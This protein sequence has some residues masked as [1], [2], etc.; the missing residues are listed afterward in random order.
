MINFE[1]S[2]RDPLDAFAPLAGDPYSALIYGGAGDSGEPDGATIVAFPSARLEARRGRA[3][4]D[5]VEV[6]DSFFAALAGLHRSRRGLSPARAQARG[7]R[8]GLVGFLG[9]ELG[10]EIEPSARGPQSPYGLPDAA[11]GAYDA[12]AIFDLAGCRTRIVARDQRAADRLAVA[13]GNGGSRGDLRASGPCRFSGLRSNFA[14][15]EYEAAVADAIEQIRRGAFFQVNLSQR[16]TASSSGPCLPIDVFCRLA[17]GAALFAAFLALDGGAVLSN[18][19]ERFFAIESAPAGWSIRAEP[20]KGTRPRSVEAVRDLEL[21]RELLSSA[22]ERAENVMI[23]D[24]TRNDLSRIC[25]PGSLREDGIC[26][27]RSFRSVHHL[28]SRISG[29]MQPGLDA[30]DALRALF[31][32]GS[33]TGAPKIEA[34][35]TISRLERTGRGP[36]CGAIGWIDDGGG[37]DFSVAIRTMI[38]E[39]AD[40]RLVVSVPVGGGVTLRSDPAAER[41]ET[42]VKASAALRALGISEDFTSG[43]G[44]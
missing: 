40:K 1:I 3:L 20:I 30:V 25:A 24:L 31:P 8:T 41:R 44:P 34:M 7:F 36:Y 19:P 26:E 28:V 14:A 4:L 35:R 33:I 6:G 18:S 37:A 29:V 21:A 5:G 13:L 32:C 17:E 22:K 38:A 39:L 23:A 12:A 11:F 27:L 9:Y 2:W 15:G 42:L 43:D 16:L 10:G